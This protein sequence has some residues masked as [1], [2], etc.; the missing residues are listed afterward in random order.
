MN[1]HETLGSEN[2]KESLNKNVLPILISSL[3]Y[4]IQTAAKET[5]VAAQSGVCY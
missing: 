4:D 1:I 5:A 2:D 3:D